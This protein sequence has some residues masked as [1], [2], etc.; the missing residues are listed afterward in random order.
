M[1]KQKDLNLR[2]LLQ[3]NGFQ[4]RRN[5][6]LCHV[7]VFSPGGRARTYMQ[8]ITLSTMYKIEGIRPDL[9]IFCT[10]RGGRTLMAY[11]RKRLKLVCLPIPPSRQ[12]AHRKTEE[13]VKI[14]LTGALSYLT[15]II[16]ELRYKDK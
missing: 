4:D 12:L 14:H 9:Y 1:R 16:N 10:G 13:E 2:S 7:S 5:K 8:P 15:I 3:L 6:P 11:G